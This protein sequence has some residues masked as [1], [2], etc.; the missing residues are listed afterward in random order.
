MMSSSLVSSTFRQYQHFA[1]DY[2]IPGLGNI[3]LINLRSD[4]I[5]SLYNKWVMLGV[6]FI[7]IEYTQAVL[8][9]SLNHAVGLGILTRNPANVAIPPKLKTSERV[10]LTETQ[11]QT[12]LI[13]A[14][15]LQPDI[16]PCI[17]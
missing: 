9:G 11:I 2:I 4:Q 6:G 8:R 14:Q 1:Q 17:I 13:A 10:V 3:I 5:Q 15:T 12:L 7:T 16:Y